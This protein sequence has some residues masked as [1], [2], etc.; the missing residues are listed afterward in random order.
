LIEEDAALARPVPPQSHLPHKKLAA[1]C[2]NSALIS[3]E[4]ALS[5]SRW[6]EVGLEI[7]SPIRFFK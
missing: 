4:N 1:I 3:S 6:P 2:F 5:P 7:A